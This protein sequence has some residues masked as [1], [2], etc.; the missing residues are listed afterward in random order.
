M[1]D[2]IEQQLRRVSSLKRQ[3]FAK[4]IRLSAPLGPNR[5]LARHPQRSNRCREDCRGC[6][7]A[8]L[9]RRFFHPDPELRKATPR[10]LVYCLPMRTLVEQTA[11]VTDLWLK[12]LAEHNSEF[13]DTAVMVHMLMGGAEPTDW[14]EHPEREAILIGTQDMLLS[15]ALNRG[16]GM[17]RYRWPVHFALTNNDCLWVFDETQLMGVGLTT[18]RAAS[19]AASEIGGVWHR[20]V[21]VDVGHFGRATSMHGRSS[22]AG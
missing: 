9:F 8:W 12:G 16:Y 2:S 18:S 6:P 19:G 14:D 10:R 21:L 1:S 22:T 5:R 20:K 15:R 3:G 4:T 13:K 11:E 7:E 17:S